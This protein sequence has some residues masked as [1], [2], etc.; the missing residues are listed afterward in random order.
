[1]NDFDEMEIKIGNYGYVALILILIMEF[2]LQMGI[3]GIVFLLASEVFP[4]K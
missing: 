4:P 3:N 1:M 2:F